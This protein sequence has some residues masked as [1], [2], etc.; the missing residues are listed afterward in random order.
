MRYNAI[1]SV[2][3]PSAVLRSTENLCIL[4]L[5]PCTPMDRPFHSFS[6]R[7]GFKENIG[8]TRPSERE[9]TCCLLGVD[10]IKWELLLIRLGF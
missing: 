2:A 10:S 7:Y 6:K 1:I 8:Q 3:Y 9:R 5:A 4:C